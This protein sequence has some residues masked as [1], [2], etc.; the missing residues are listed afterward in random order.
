MARKNNPDIVITDIM[1][2]EMDGIE[3]TRKLKSDFNTSH[4]PVIMLTAR[5][6]IENEIEG[7]E[8]GADD[9]LPKPFGIKRLKTHMISLLQNR[10]KLWQA[11]TMKDHIKP[12]DVQVQSMD[13]KFVEHAMDIVE[14]NIENADFNVEM[15]CREIGM[16]RMH[17][18]RKLKGLFNQSPSEF[19]RIIRL[20]RAAQLLVDGQLNVSEVI[21][22]V[23]F[24]SRTYFT[25]AFKQYYGVSPKEYVQKNCE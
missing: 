14:K 9:Y 19:I 23:G 6:T 11:F 5:S 24:N 18:N 10:E 2:P 7:L 20:K 1:M 22:K 12:S 16:S 17:L 21:Y 13:E 8:E 4:I 15:F 3:L 25:K